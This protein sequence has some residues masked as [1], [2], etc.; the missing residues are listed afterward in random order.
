VDPGRRSFVRSGTRPAGKPGVGV[1]SFPLLGVLA[2]LTTLA[3]VAAC[4]GDDA[5]GRS[6]LAASFSY[7]V[8]L[9]TTGRTVCTLDGIRFTDTSSGDPTSW[10]W[11][12]SDG[13]TSTDQNPVYEPIAGS[14]QELT[15]TLEVRRDG[16]TDTATQTIV[17]PLC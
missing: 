17:L 2:L 4:S 15:A 10:R 7:E 16:T 6:S 9:D 3:V 12:F 14:P 8:D 1:L 11:S 5:P 13:Q